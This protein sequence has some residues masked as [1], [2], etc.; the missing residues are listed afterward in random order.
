[1]R[2]ALPHPDLAEEINDLA[3]MMQESGDYN[4]SEALFLEAIAMKRRLLG[5]KHPEIA[6]GLNNLAFVLQDKGELARAEAT[7]REALQMQRELLGDVHPDVA[8]TLNNLAFVQDDKGDL[9]GALATERESLHI[10]RTLFPGD[11]PE[12]ARIMNRIGYWLIESGQY[13]EAEKNL[14][15]ALAMRRRLVGEE[16]PDV[17]SSLTHLAILQVAQ[18]DYH[19]A[20]ES[21]VTAT[22]IS[23]KVF[24]PTHWRTAVAESVQGAALTGLGQYADAERLLTHGNTILNADQGALPTYRTRARGYLQELYRRW[25]RPVPAATLALI[26]AA[27]V[28][29][30][31]A[32]A[33]SAVVQ[34]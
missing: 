7:Y 4:A 27:E 16:H 22:N 24:S 30:A 34:K 12:V 5:D 21:A 25:R 26:G 28:Q 8:N 9:A 11:H 31:Q 2:G 29:N 3:F 13:A 19:A 1:L 33:V 17:A 23:T 6:M 14:R 18:H 20:L 32:T 10:Y 15:E